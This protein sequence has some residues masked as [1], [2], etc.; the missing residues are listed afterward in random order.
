MAMLNRSYADRRCHL[1]RTSLGERVV[2][3]SEWKIDPRLYNLAIFQP[4]DRERQRLTSSCDDD[5]RVL[6]L[7]KEPGGSVGIERAELTGR[8]SH[9]DVSHAPVRR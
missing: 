5:H 1:A 9:F 3:P 7:L 8:R 4:D 2:R 6:M